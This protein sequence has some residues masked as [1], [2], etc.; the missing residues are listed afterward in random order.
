MSARQESDGLLG[1][2]FL[3]AVDTWIGTRNGTLHMTCGSSVLAYQLLTGDPRDRFTVNVLD[4]HC[5]GTNYHHT[6]EDCI[7]T[8]ERDLVSRTSRLAEPFPSRKR[9]LGLPPVLLDL[10][11]MARETMTK[12]GNMPLAMNEKWSVEKMKLEEY[13]SDARVQKV[14]EDEEFQ[15]EIDEDLTFSVE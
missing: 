9:V 4:E 1:M 3:Q 11:K 6:L 10:W 13:V 8:S 5:L 2:D 12:I 15:E 14:P 7:D